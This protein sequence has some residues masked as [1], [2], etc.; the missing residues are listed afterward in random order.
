MPI[1]RLPIEGVDGF[2]DALGAPYS[3]YV[4]I[5]GEVVGR[6]VRVEEQRLVIDTDDRGEAQA[7]ERNIP[8]GTW[9]SQEEVDAVDSPDSSD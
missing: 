9:I 4:T 8:P 2:A 6:L 3:L 7:E 5:E 1:V